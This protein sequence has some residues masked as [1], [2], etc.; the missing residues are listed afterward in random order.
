MSLI[1]CEENQVNARDII[2]S[3]V[4]RLHLVISGS[5]DPGVFHR[6]NLDRARL[7]ARLALSFIFHPKTFI[8]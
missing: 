2:N 4:Y 5:L 8:L 7:S 1:C 6:K 3:R